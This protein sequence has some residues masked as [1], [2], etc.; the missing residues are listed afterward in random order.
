MNS[1]PQESF[2]ESASK[3]SKLD[4]G[5]QDE[6]TLESIDQQTTSIGIH[7]IPT[8]N[9][10]KRSFT[11]IDELPCNPPPLP[12]T[13]P[14]GSPSKLLYNYPDLTGLQACLDRVKYLDK[15]NHQDN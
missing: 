12:V 11:K 6:K 15:M 9:A 13:S 14:V 8:L 10:R 7:T 3:K 5:R 1:I 4:T 2:T